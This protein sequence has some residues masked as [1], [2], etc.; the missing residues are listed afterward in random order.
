MEMQV[1]PVIFV[2]SDSAGDTGEAAVRAAAV[3][4]EPLQ[5][6]IRRVPFLHDTSDIDRL[7]YH[8]LERKGAIVFTLVLP[9]LRDH[10]IQECERKGILYIDLLGPIIRTLESTLN[11]EARH[12]P[13][14]IHRLDEDYFKKVEAVEF[15]VKYDDGRDFNGVLQADI[16]LVGVSRTSKT[17]LSMYLAHKTYKVANVPLVPEIAPPEQ[18]FTVSSHKIIGLRIDP[19]KLNAIRTER[20]KALGL[21]GNA[22]YA[23]TERILKELEFADNIMKRIGCEVIDVSNRAVEETA[24]LIIDILRSR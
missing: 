11:Q 12:E 19:L 5:V 21:P 22:T 10:L 15:A 20:L 23:N 7:I 3:Q 4:F 17:P 2:A 18:L 1:K 16:V 24:S 14:M 9:V 8:V 13:G 6:E